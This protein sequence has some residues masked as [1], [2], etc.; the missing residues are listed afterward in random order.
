MKKRIIFHIDVNSAYLS[1]EA[2]YRLQHGDTVDLREIPSVVGG[3]EE[4]RHGI[5]LA[6]SIPAKKFKIKT[7]E[8]LWQARQKCPGLVVVRPNYYLY[9]QC[10]SALLNL[11]R[12]YSDRIQP[13][14][15]DE[16]F[17]DFTGMEKVF[18]DDAVTVAN[19]IR[20]RIKKELGFTVNI[21]ISSNKLLAKMGSELKKPDMVHTL[22]PEE[23][24]YKLWPLPVEDLFMVGRATAPK[25]HSMGIYTIGDLARCDIELLKYKLKSWGI[26]LWNFANGIEDSSVRSH[27]R[28]SNI[29]GIGNSTTIRFDVEDRE[30]AHKVLLSLVETVAMRLRHEGFCCRVVAVSIKTKDLYSFSHQRKLEVPTDCTNAIFAETKKLFDEAW[31]GEPIRHLGVRVSDLYRDDSVQLSLFCK[32]WDKQL[33][34]DRAIDDIRLK[35]GP[36]SVIRS[37]FLQSGINPLQGGVVE[38]FP[39]MSSIL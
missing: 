12:D 22:F 6:K 33:K 11:L 36:R 14:S 27:G 29:K 26:T 5:V 37:T 25:L 38:D 3:D 9:M 15:I 2:V 30:T 10:S 35:Y 20:E 7:G 1:W 13:F 34:I 21:G 39:I 19:K 4:T 17:L 31:K 32:D 23:I 24:P 18:R 8:T 16:F 28:I